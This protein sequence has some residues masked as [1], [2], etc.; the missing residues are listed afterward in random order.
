MSFSG[1]FISICRFFIEFVG[2]LMI[3]SYSVRSVG[4]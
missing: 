4:G 2:I 3:S 1:N